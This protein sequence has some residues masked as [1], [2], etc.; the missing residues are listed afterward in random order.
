MFVDYQASLE[1]ESRNG[2]GTL[3]ADNYGDYLVQAYLQPSATVYLQELS[4]SERDSYLAEHRWITWAEGAATFS[5]E[6]YVSSL[7]RTKGLPAFDD[8]DMFK[9]EPQLFS[10]ATT[11][12]RHFTDFS[13]R[14]STGDPTAAVDGE[15]KHIVD[16][17]NAMYFLG[18]DDPA[19]VGHW[20]IRHGAADKDTALPVIVNLATSLENL[21]KDVNT[22]L[23]WDAGHA[24]DEDPENFISWV[25]EITGYGQ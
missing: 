3:T 13:L 22:L 8:L 19:T 23:Y 24:T 1:L 18:Q 11:D 4:N 12:T 14:L 9:P 15:L 5:W 2:F 21:G 16:L 6:D 7:G 17:M 20:W 10:D 25:G